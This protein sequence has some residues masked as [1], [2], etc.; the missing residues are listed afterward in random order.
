M[1]RGRP[2]VTRR[3]LCLE[4]ARVLAELARTL[5]LAAVDMAPRTCSAQESLDLA[6]SRTPVDAPPDW[7][8]VIKPGEVSADSV[9]GSRA[10]AEGLHLSVQLDPDAADGA[11]DDDADGAGGESKILKLFT[12]PAFTSQALANFLRKLMGRSRGGADDTAGGDL[13]V[14]SARHVRRAGPN[15]TPARVQFTDRAGAA[16]GGGRYPEWDVHRNRYRPDWCRVLDVPLTTPADVAQGAVPRDDVLRQRLSRVGLGP[17]VLRR[18]ADGDDLDIEA[19][20]ELFVDLQSG[21]SPPEHVYLERRK[22]AR[23]LGVLI[24][25][26]AS[27]SATD[28]DQEGLSVHEHQRR[29]AAT[30]AATLEELGDRVAVYGFRSQGRD[31]VHLLAI[32][33]FDQ[34][35]GAVGR[36]R[37]NQLR[38]SGYTRIGAAIRGAGDILSREAGTPN[39]LLLVLS[40]GFPYDHGYEGR[41]ARADVGKALEELRAAGLACL[42]LTIG[43]PEVERVFGAAGHAAA[44][45]LAELSPRMDELFMTALAELAAPVPR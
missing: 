4:G 5:P 24:L 17:K 19:L 33:T 12:A 37:L 18:R 2:S 31:A 20:T 10:A 22:L 41:Y 9:A 44:A 1:L 28:T 32:K 35:F 45:S 38:A 39:R 30:L 11:D 29:A 7:F 27:G 13:Q 16:L 26:D 43:T 40:D 14:G 3:Y 36:A 23:D 25:V 15:A 6:M 42:C 34:R 21:Y 8:G